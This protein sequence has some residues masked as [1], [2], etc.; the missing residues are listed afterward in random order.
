MLREILTAVV[1]VLL[2]FVAAIIPQ[3]ATVTYGGT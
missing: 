1:R 3:F 2:R